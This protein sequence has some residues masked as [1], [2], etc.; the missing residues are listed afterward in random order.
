MELHFGERPWICSGKVKFK[1]S[2]RHLNR[3]IPP[4]EQGTRGLE[5]VHLLVTVRGRPRAALR[6][7]ELALFPHSSLGPGLSLTRDRCNHFP[8]AMADPVLSAALN[9]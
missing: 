2:V 7:E 9:G 8:K 4:S 6:S 3:D 5:G 1:V